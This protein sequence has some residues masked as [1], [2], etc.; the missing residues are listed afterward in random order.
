MCI[1]RAVVVIASLIAL[2]SC[3]R[4]PHHHHAAPAKPE[5]PAAAP[6]ETP[7]NEAVCVLQP[8]SGS[9]VIGTVRF[10]EES[11]RL[12]INA[13][14]SGLSPGAKHAIH[15]HSFGDLRS[16]DGSSLGGHY[17]PG[18]HVHGGP[19]SRERHAGDL[20]N[21]SA[22]GAG[23]AQYELSVDGLGIAEI[24]GRSVVV[25]AS[26]DDFTSQPAGNAGARIGVGVIGHAARSDPAKTATSH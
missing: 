2:V 18:G 6:S 14:V 26:A 7:A 25:H 19:R 15:I 10:T 5:T 12:V 13:H 20:G 9:H 8:A 21:L 17:N 24:L 3:G 4:T 1:Q 22:D 11:G 23:E 16:D